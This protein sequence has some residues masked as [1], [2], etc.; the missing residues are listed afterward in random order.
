VSKTHLVRSNAKSQVQEVLVGDTPLKV[1]QAMTFV[2]DFGDWWEFE[3][4]LE[5]VDP[6]MSLKKPVVLE[7]HGEP[8]DQYPGWDDEE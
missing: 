3:V 7:A 2:F 4:V 5:R 1:G 8:P 6:G